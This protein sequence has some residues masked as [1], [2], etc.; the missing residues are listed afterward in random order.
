MNCMVCGR[1]LAPGEGPLCTECLLSMPLIDSAAEP[2]ALWNKLTGKFDFEHAT[3][4]SYYV[5]EHFLSGFMR[6]CKFGSKPWINASL[7]GYLMDMLA[8]SPWP[9]DIDTVVPVP[10]HW[11]R[12][13][14]RG[15]NQVTP[16]VNT[17]STRWHLPVEK[18]CLYR[19][20]LVTSQLK[21]DWLQR[22]QKQ[23]QAFAIRHPERLEGKHILLVD[24]VCTS[25]ATLTA[26]ADLLH[27]IPGVRVSVLC[28]AL[29]LQT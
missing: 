26:C 1:E 6:Q 29:T 2:N 3:A 17:L 10:V 21:G 4:L 5:P 12:V 9:Y 11:W 8:D 25:G 23:R 22:R 16:I 28:L 7:T 18:S 27:L 20:H 15:Y 24:D 19:R 13:Y 14:Q